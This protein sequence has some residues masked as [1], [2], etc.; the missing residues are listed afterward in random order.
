MSAV[1][2]HP[3]ELG[4]TTAVAQIVRDFVVNMPFSSGSQYRGFDE[5][6]RTE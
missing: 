4:M 6:M 1:A 5:L 3:D 2:D